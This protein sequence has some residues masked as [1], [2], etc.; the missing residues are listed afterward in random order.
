MLNQSQL[1][2]TLDSILNNQ[3]SL[4][5]VHDIQMF[6]GKKIDFDEWIAQIEEVSYLTGKPEYVFTLAKSLGTPY[7][8]ITHTPS[9]TAWSELKRK[10]QE[11]YFLMATDI[12]VSTDLLRKQCANELLTG[13]RCVIKA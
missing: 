10:L 3:Q 9:N 5:R 8:M 6:N 7:Q 2:D 4:Q 1:N 12:H 11:V 13:P